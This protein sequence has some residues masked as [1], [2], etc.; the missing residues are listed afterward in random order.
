MDDLKNSQIRA[1]I[2][3]LRDIIY[4]DA[5]ST[6]PTPEP[7]V[8]AMV[9]YYHN[10]NA[11]TGRGAYKTAVKST[12]KFDDARD[13]IAHLINCA[14]DEVIFTKNTTEAINL[15]AKGLD[16]KKGDSIILPNIEH[17]SN[18]LPWLQLKKHGINLKVIKAN[19]FGVIDAADVEK[20]VDENTKLITTTHISNSIG[21]CQPIYEMGDIAQD[22][23]ILYLVDAAQSAGHMELDVKKIKA[24]FISFPG[25]KGLLGP[26]GTGFLYGKKESSENLEPVNLGGGTVSNVTEEDY[27]L[28]PVPARFEAGTQNIAGFIGLGAAVDYVK[29]IGIE[30]IQ[31]YSMKLTKYMYERINEI[32]NSICYGDPENIHGI[33]AFNIE[34]M[35]SH[36]VAKILD[37]IKNIC[38]RSGYHC[39][40]P[41]IRH[42]GADALGGTVRASVHCYNNKEEIDIFAETVNEI[43]KFAG[44]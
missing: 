8:N 6:T 17:H 37:E 31:R 41:A 12:S 26:V 2:P 3:L 32:D 9:D 14:K 42:V 10:F 29:R 38:V 35:N 4:L 34:G 15:V 1:D 21:S 20:A 5:A 25:H 22:N 7:V 19:E 23:N 30:N 27:V 11:N 16:F 40:I 28:E 13:K 36:D 44:G 18:F 24:D 33:V 43:S 39:A